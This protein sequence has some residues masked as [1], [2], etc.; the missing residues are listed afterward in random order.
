[1]TALISMITLGKKSPVVGLSNWSTNQGRKRVARNVRRIQKSTEIAQPSYT[2]EFLGGVVRLAVRAPW[3]SFQS[4]HWNLFI[5]K[6]ARIG[7][8]KNVAT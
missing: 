1:V 2:Y 8:V 5:T 4:D 7:I 3:V 6:R